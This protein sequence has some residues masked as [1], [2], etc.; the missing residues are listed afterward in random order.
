MFGASAQFIRLTDEH[1]IKPFDCGD[2]DLNEYLAVDAKLYLNQ[3]LA[4]TYL[5]ENNTDTIAFF[6]VSNDKIAYQDFPTNSQWNKM[7]RRFDRRKHLKSYPCVKIGRLGVSKLYSGQE[8]GTKLVNYIKFFFTDKNKTGC[9]FTTVD[10]YKTALGFYEKN[11]FD[12]LT[13]ADIDDE[14]RLMFFD[15]T[16]ITNE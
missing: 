4:V 7:R 13:N 16:Q 3:L 2:D 10:A 15:L 9:R 5:V 6:S 1:E 12:Y 14:T 11:G 8:Y